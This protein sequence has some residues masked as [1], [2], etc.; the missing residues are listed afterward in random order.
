[1]FYIIQ[2]TL[3]Q[4]VDFKNKSVAL[5]IKAGNAVHAEYIYV[6]V[7]SFHIISTY[8]V[9]IGAFHNVFTLRSLTVDT[10]YNTLRNKHRFLK[11]KCSYQ[12]DVLIHFSE[13]RIEKIQKHI[14]NSIFLGDFHF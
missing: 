13:N 3:F 2:N 4:A 9:K 6:Y 12:I 7:F 14:T 11:K 5:I 10:Q 1:M 8:Y